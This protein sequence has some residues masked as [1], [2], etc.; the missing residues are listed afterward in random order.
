MAVTQSPGGG[1]H[2]VNPYS[3]IEA[4]CTCYRSPAHITHYAGWRAQ[5]Q[6]ATLTDRDAIL[7]E[8]P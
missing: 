7:R 6:L 8:T 3:T 4:V 5:Q 1:M 2:L